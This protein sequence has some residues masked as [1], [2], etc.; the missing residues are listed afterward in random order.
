MKYV[1]VFL[2]SVFLTV[3]STYIKIFFLY[4]SEYIQFSRV[5]EYGKHNCDSHIFRHLGQ[6][7]ENCLSMA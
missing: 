3:F 6:N 5:E 7:S 4:V 2:C 1:T